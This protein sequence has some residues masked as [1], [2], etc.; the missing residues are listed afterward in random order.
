MSNPLAWSVL[1]GAAP[2]A[3]PL[4]ARVRQAVASPGAASPSAA[5]ARQLDLVVHDKKG[6][7]V[8]HLQPDD[9]TIAGSRS[10]VRLENLRLVEQLRNPIQLFSLEVTI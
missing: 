10:P 3:A 2:A 5:D 7:P 8:L 6:K 1:L 4:L 9:L